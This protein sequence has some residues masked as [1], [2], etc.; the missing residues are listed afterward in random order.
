MPFPELCDSFVNRSQRA[1]VHYRLD[2]TE[3]CARLIQKKA[4]KKWQCKDSWSSRTLFTMENLWNDFMTAVE[5]KPMRNDW[6]KAR[7]VLR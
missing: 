6:G 7:N 1:Q 5:H 3:L 4:S 2:K